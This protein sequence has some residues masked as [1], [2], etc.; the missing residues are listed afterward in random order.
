MLVNSLF[1]SLF[2]NSPN[3]RKASFQNGQ[4]GIPPENVGI[5]FY[6]KSC[7]TGVYHCQETLTVSPTPLDGKLWLSLHIFDLAYEKIFFVCLVKSR[8]QSLLQL[9][10][11]QKNTVL[12]L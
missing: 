1:L 2:Q 8:S 10:V 4:V 9:V 6:T 3:C 7:L 12:E 5:I 11:S